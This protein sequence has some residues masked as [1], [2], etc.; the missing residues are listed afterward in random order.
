[1]STSAPSAPRVTRS[2]SASMPGLK[3][4]WKLTAAIELPLGAARENP[5]AP[6]R[7]W[8]IGFCISTAAPLRQLLEDAENL[9]AGDGDVEH[10]GRR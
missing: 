2:R 8:P 9:I 6:A 1:M 10:R 5:L 4:S 7:S 3:R